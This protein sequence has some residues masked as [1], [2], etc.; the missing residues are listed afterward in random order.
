VVLKLWYAKTFKVVHELAYFI[1]LDKKYIYS[2]SFYL[3]GS[4]NKFLDFCVAYFPCWFLK[5]TVII[6]HSHVVNVRY[7]SILVF[8]RFNRMIFGRL[9]FPGTS[10]H[11]VTAQV[12]QMVHDQKFGNYWCNSY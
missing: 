12:P 4:V 11:V 3:S 1:F 7:E 2:Y 5:M 10:W 6:S 9:S 8:Q